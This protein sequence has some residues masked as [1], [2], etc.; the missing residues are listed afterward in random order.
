MAGN[1]IMKMANPAHT[2]YR[3]LLVI[4]DAPSMVFPEAGPPPQSEASTR[5]VVTAE[6]PTAIN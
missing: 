5:G 1:V 6:R 4:V 2:P 3:E